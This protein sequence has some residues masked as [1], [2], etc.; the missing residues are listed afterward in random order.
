MPS[1]FQVI[2]VSTS[3]HWMPGVQLSCSWPL[4][5]NNEKTLLEACEWYQLLWEQLIQGGNFSLRRR[6]K[7][8]QIH[9]SLQGKS[10]FVSILIS[11]GM[12]CLLK[13]LGK[14]TSKS[15][16]VST[17]DEE[18]AGANHISDWL[19]HWFAFGNYFLTLK[20]ETE[21][22]VPGWLAL[23]TTENNRGK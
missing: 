16:C 6:M 19:S 2:T 21:K 5:Y 17:C 13:K 3:L 8:T 15:M 11:L 4:V 12:N 14:Q 1:N 20:K 9:S 10:L 22:K 23:V 18:E 7:V